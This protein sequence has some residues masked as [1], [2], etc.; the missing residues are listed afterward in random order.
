MIRVLQFINMYNNLKRSNSIIKKI[1][2][3]ESIKPILKIMSDLGLIAWYKFVMQNNQKYI[4]IKL[5]K[6]EIKI[7]P[8]WTAKRICYTAAEL[9]KISCS[10]KS[11]IIYTNDKGW[12]VHMPYK[13]A[14][15][16][17]LAIAKIYI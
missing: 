7:V 5:K 12:H 16:G 2:F 13:K 8:L 6:G 15:K 17:G 1:K 3:F 11:Y 10:D 9:N 4:I 14:L